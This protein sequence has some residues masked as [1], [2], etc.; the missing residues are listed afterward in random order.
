MLEG[1]RQKQV[2]AVLEKD[3]NEIFQRM[4]LTMIDGGMVSIAAVKITPDLFDARVYLSFFQ[5]KDAVGTLNKIQE[6]AWEIKKELTAR[7]RHQLRSMPQLTFY[8]DDTLEYVDKMEVLFNEIKKAP[9]ISPKGGGHGE[10][11]SEKAPSIPDETGAKLKD[12]G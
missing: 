8:I 7:V 5:V 3:L 6:Q 4:G 9:S 11:G 12:E 2:A 1:K 10:D